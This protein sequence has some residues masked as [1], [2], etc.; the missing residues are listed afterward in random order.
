MDSP[1][2]NSSTAR[3]PDGKDPLQIAKEVR[4]T[5]VQIGEDPQREGLLKTPER[6]SQA[7]A[8]LT[9]GYQ[10][11]VA[12][13]IN[14]AIFEEQ[15]DEMV[16]VKNI[17]FYSMCEHHMLPFFGVVHVGY[18]PNGK[19]LGLSKIPR[20]V[21]MFARRLQL[22]ERMTQQIAQALMESLEPLGVGVVAEGQHLCMMMRGVQKEQARA[23][24]S[25]MLG[26]FRKS[27]QTRSEFLS[28]I[29]HSSLK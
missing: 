6:V 9:S 16:I 24:T 19:V 28:L 10:S 23:L 26:S 25:A 8:Y 5:L 1:K 22:Q 2:N 7:M 15:Y 29:G 17:E 13:V 20:L 21:E 11:S 3:Q 14:G 4:R 18:I 12:G 27:Q